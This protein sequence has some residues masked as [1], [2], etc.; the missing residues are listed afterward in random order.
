MLASSS[1]LP[2]IL[3]WDVPTGRRLKILHGHTAPVWSIAFS[4]DGNQL[5]SISADRTVKLWDIATGE[6][7]NTLIGHG[8]GLYSV[9]TFLPSG[10]SGRKGAITRPVE[11]TQSLNYM[12][13]SAGADRTIRIWD[14]QTG[15]CLQTLEGHTDC[16]YDIAI[17]PYRQSLVSASHDKTLRYWD[18]HTGKCTAILPH[19]T[20]LWSVAYH[21]NGDYL[22]TSGWNNCITIWDV[23]AQEIIQSLEILNPYHGMMIRDCQGLTSSQKAMLQNLGAI[24]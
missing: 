24:L 3:L 8:D 1:T 6:C 5:A 19:E 21:P 20:P 7:L 16:I 9:K 12:I 23:Q 15:D 18:L 22:A 14:S 10:R 2:I 4:P 13:A 11:P 17:H